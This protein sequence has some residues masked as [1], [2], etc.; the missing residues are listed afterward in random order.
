LKVIK[1]IALK[2]F[3]ILVTSSLFFFVSGLCTCILSFFFLRGL[4]VFSQRMAGQVTHSLNA[5]GD[6]L[7][8]GVII[9]HLSYVNI[10]FIFIVPALTMRLVAEEKIM[11][12]FDL[13]L[14]SPITA[15]QIVLGKYIAGFLTVLTLIM[16]SFI[17]PLGIAF[18]GE[19][20][21]G[22]MMT[23]YMGLI[24]LGG[25]YVA[26]GLFS[27]SLSPSPLVSVVTGIILNPIFSMV[28]ST[29]DLICF[30]GTDFNS[31]TKI[32]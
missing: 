19:L 13:L 18:V 23:S 1:S 30:L 29:F 9:N 27:S 31:A 8:F 5:V 25:L 6:N 24:L 12:T 28:Y 16:I 17:Y 21:W 26:I 3:K 11:K 15:T 2:D 32:K 14:T 7:H 22:P 10:L 4:I 20:Q